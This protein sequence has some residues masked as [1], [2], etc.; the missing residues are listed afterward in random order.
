ML[1]VVRVV[2]LIQEVDSEPP[3]QAGLGHE[4][5][6]RETGQGGESSSTIGLRR[7]SDAPDLRF[8]VVLC[9]RL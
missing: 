3:R 5:V 7:G 1:V 6:L 9:A 8:N 4:G 2:H